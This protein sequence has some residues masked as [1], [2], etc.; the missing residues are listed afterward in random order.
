MRPRRGEAMININFN[1]YTIDELSKL[2]RDL[3]DHLRLR[4]DRES[5]MA[6]HSYEI[7]DT[8]SFSDNGGLVTGKIIRFNKKSVTIECPHGTQW[9]VSPQLLGKVVSTQNAGTP[10]NILEAKYH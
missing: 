9:R 3:V 8:V 5:Q 6:M 1:N 10:R 4:C 7:G 2:N